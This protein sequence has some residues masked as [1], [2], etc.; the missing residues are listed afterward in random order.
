MAAAAQ[1]PTVNVPG[2][3]APLRWIQ[4]PLD[5]QLTKTGIVITAPGK[6]DKYID[7]RGGYAP[8][9]APRLVFDASDGDFIVST[10]V[11]HKFVGR[12]DSGG[13]IV[14]ADAAH[15]FK[16]GFER[17]Y[18]GAHRVVSVVTNV[19]S[20]DANAMQIDSDAAYLEVARMGDAFCLY[21][22]EDG[23]SWYLVRVFNFK[24][25]GSLKVGLI[26][27][28]PEG[29]DATI[30]F[31]DLKYSRTRIKDVWKGQ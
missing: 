5:Y 9:N 17:D 28:C 4:A 29:K 27:Q 24:Y 21:V 26:A 25:T 23:K 15:W 20:D 19:Y 2:I 8:D 14:E 7:S 13:L 6:T 1:T 10:A 11:S 22:S 18:T 30:R 31:S 12:W 3:D 16:F